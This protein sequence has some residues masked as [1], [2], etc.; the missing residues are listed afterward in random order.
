MPRPASSFS[1]V[2]LLALVV[3]AGAAGADPVWLSK[4]DSGQTFEAGQVAGLFGG[5]LSLSTAGA[6]RVLVVAA[7]PRQ[8]DSNEDQVPVQTAGRASIEVIGPVRAGDLVLA[9]GRNDGTATAFA[10]SE[11]TPAQLPLLVG[12]ALE[13]NPVTGSRSI[14]V[15]VGLSEWQA[16]VALLE[17]RDALL[18]AQELELADLRGRIIE[19]EDLATVIESLRQTTERLVALEAA[20]KA[21][22]LAP[23]PLRRE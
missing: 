16:L 19:L 5:G 1:L 21:E 18:A 11:L 17:A 13:A 22:E 3:P 10:L 7:A 6:D 14:E 2:L 23:L 4:L 15:L 12:R 8:R 9:S 20:R